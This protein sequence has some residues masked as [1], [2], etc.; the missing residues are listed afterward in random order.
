[1]SGDSSGPTV[2]E[3]DEGEHWRFAIMSSLHELVGLRKL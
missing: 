3:K 1:M 2:K